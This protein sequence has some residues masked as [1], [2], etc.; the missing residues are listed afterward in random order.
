MTA[1]ADPR[2]I[3]GRPREPSVPIFSRSPGPRWV[4]YGLVLGVMSIIALVWGPDEPSIDHPSVS[5]T[6]AFCVMGLSTI[7]S[8]FAMRHGRAPFFT[9]PLLRYAATLAIGALFVVVTTQ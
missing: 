7:F 8:G 1:F 6:M 3:G 9:Q 2:V 4:A 5:M